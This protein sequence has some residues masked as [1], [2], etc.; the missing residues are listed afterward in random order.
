MPARPLREGRDL[1][2]WC[3]GLAAAAVLFTV[4]LLRWAS[5]HSTAYDLAFFDQVVWSASAGHGLS[6]SFVGYSFFGQHLEP[7]LLLLVPLDRIHATPVW[8]F[9]AQSLALGLA[10][11]PLWALTRCWL[12]TRRAAVIASAAYLLQVGVARAAGFDF[13]TEALGVPFVF[14]ALY[15][16][17]RG[18]TPLLL[19]AGTVPL[20]CKED[21][22]LVSAGAGVLAYL[23]HRRRAG[24]V[25]AGGAVVA[26]AVEVLV[27]MPRLR[28]GAPGDLIDRYRYLGATPGSVVSH[29]LTEPQSWLGHLLSAPAGPALLLALAAVGLLPL[30][31]PATLL[32]VLPAMLVALISADPFQSG[33]RLQYGLPATPLL[34]AAALAAWRGRPGRRIGAAA[35][36]L[37][38][39]GAALTWLLAAPLPWGPG[40]DRVEL[41]GA[42]RLAAAGA[43]LSRI[44]PGVPVAATGSVLT[45]LA[46]RPT[47]YELPAGVG[48]EWIAVDEDGAV[49]DDSRAAGYDG[50]VSSLP[51][52][53]YSLVAEGGG[54]AL[55]RLGV[56]RPA[57]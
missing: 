22:A 17:A 4:E 14:L 9:A 24:L 16:A 1:T 54:V 15:G 33:L 51:G 7:A 8:L 40:P 13:H 20:L 50:A 29:L 52:R 21:G 32:A 10:V 38:L 3:L 26:G 57:R 43:V 23:V 37:L 30:L 34:V 36:A 39:G 46:E 48:V 6:S 41:D 11:V 27:L 47:I 28:D 56:R 31:R 53:G 18:S 5:F 42:G 49:S 19:I 35:P 55:W 2:P 45:H 44:P 25:L 12:G